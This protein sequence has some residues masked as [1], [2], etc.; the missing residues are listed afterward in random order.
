MELA[1]PAR[2]GDLPAVSALLAQAIEEVGPGRGGPELLAESGVPPAPEP[3]ALTA[4]LDHPDRALLVGTFDDV[5]VGAAGL[6]LRRWPAGDQRVAR[7]LFLYVE[8]AARGVSVG[9]ALLGEILRWAGDHDATGVEADALPG[10]R[11]TKN[12]FER[13]GMVTRRLVVFRRLGAP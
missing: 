5:V 8:P 9:E 1:R 7:L 12:F 3:A 13:A 11:E 4:L 6:E 2:H 10:D